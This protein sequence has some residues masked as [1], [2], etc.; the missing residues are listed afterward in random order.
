[1]VTRAASGTRPRR[2]PGVAAWVLWTLSMLGLACAAWLAHLLRQAGR[3]E[4]AFFEA[5]IVPEVVAAVSAATVGAVLASRRPAHP[6]GWLL[7]GLGLLV[8]A[9]DGTSAYAH[10]GVMVRPGA[11]PAVGYLS[12]AGWGDGWC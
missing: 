10:Y 11:L 8:P 9:S 12:R 7:L 1:V 3:S 6:V 2:G 5:G 4:L